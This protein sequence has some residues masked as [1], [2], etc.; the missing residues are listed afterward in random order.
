[1]DPNGHKNGKKRRALSI[2]AKTF[3][4]RQDA[5]EITQK[6]LVGGCRH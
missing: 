3:D 4:A 6:L 5:V 2:G 1:M